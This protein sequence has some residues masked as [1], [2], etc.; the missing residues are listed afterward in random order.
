MRTIISFLFIISF[1]LASAQ[2]FK[3]FSGRLVYEITNLDKPN[4]EPLQMSVFSIDSLVRIE[5]PSPVFGN[6]AF[7]KHIVK[8]KSFLLISLD[9]S[10]NYAI[11]GDFDK[12]DSVVRDKK[13]Y[14]KK[15]FGS[16][17]IAGIKS[18]KLRLTFKKSNK[19]FNC[20]YAK[21]IS[22]KY[23]DAYNDFPGLPTEYYLE[24]EDGILK[25]SLLKIE[26]T[27]PHYDL[28]GIPS[29]YE[30]VTF[31]EFVNILTEGK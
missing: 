19:S 15:K 8:K 3:P 12:A 17:K 6:Q 25:Y 5:T 21:N 26:Y 24:T 30:L 22:A 13:Y 2:T 23:L 20:L 14:W 10:H 16:K 27:T 1:F 7:V 31:D 28:F 29:N 4:D 18:K 11:K 9:Q